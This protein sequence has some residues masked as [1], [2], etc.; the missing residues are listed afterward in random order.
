[1]RCDDWKVVRFGDNFK[2]KH[3]FAFKGEFITT[4]KSNAILITPGNF[5]IGGGLKFTKNKYYTGDIPCEYILAEN[6]LIITMTDLSKLGDTLG[7]AGL[8]P[9]SE[10]TIFLHNQRIGLVIFQSTNIDKGF[11]HWRL[12]SYD[13]QQYIV[14]SATGSTVKHTS[15]KT[16][17]NFVCLLPPLDMQRQIATTLSA[18][19]DKIELNNAINDNL[20]Q[21]AQAIFKSW[22]VDFEPEIPFTDVVQ[23]LG[24]GTPKT[25]MNEY[26][27]GDVPFYTPKDAI[28][29]YVLQTEKTLTKIGLKHCNSRLFSKNTVFVT[30]RGTVGKLSLA[31]K[32]MAMNQ[33]CYALVG[34]DGY[35]QY[36]IFHLAQ[37][38]V[39]NLKHKANGAV[40]DTIVTRDF[41]TE[42]TINPSKE[43]VSGFEVAVSPLYCTMLNNLMENQRLSQLRDTLLPR[44]MSGEIDVSQVE[45]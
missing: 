31:G 23:V 39:Q 45:V 44:L 16:I 21:Q 22:F 10:D 18:I 1:M 12:R 11:L 26:W 5:N 14:G 6:D 3:G 20:E 4:S 29:N 37:L 2:V 40:F 38:A 41:E 7:Y 32:P 8:I 15:P 35:G 33:S 19:D 42:Y 17:E 24:G 9:K 43:V 30:A 28:K 25:T 13:Y 36:Y 34:H 27:N